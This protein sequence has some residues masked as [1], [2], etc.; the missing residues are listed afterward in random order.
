VKD[1]ESQTEHDDHQRSFTLKVHWLRN[2]IS[3]LRSGGAYKSRIANNVFLTAG[4]FMDC[5]S[6]HSPEVS[7][8]SLNYTQKML[9]LKCV[10][11]FRL[12]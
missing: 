5:D 12:R 4:S 8:N 10:A 11:Q 7:L 2:R 3:S 1:G 6:Y 9:A